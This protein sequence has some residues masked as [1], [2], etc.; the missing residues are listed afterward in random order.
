MATAVRH[1]FSWGK[2]GGEIGAL[3]EEAGVFSGGILYFIFSSFYR[4]SSRL[5][6][7]SGR[8]LFFFSHPPPWKTFQDGGNMRALGSAE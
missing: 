8:F 2:A 4:P 6:G 1:I 7:N 3:P 5:I